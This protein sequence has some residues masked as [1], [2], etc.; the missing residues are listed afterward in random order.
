MPYAKLIAPKPVV[1][2][3]FKDEHTHEELSVPIVF[4]GHNPGED[5]VPLVVNEID[6]GKLA[7]ARECSNF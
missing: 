2:A 3:C 4:W 1:R 5:P 6:G 7:N